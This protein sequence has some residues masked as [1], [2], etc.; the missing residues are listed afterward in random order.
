MEP[1][2]RAKRTGVVNSWEAQSALID[3][4]Q[5]D[6][7]N[8]TVL[9]DT[10][11]LP[12]GYY[13]VYGFVGGNAAHYRFSLEHRNAANA[14]SLATMHGSVTAGLAFQAG[15]TNRKVALNERFRIRVYYDATGTFGSSIVWTRRAS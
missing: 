14:A 3:N 7:V 15:Y 11:Q 13:D 6:P 9:V 12:A 2:D 5:T 10:G 8:G 4:E 1:T